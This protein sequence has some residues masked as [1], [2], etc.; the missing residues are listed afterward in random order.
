MTTPE[1]TSASAAWPLDAHLKRGLFNL[2]PVSSSSPM[3]KTCLAVF[4][5]L[6][7]AHAE[8]PSAPATWKSQQPMNA[9]AAKGDNWWQTFN[10]A[11]LTKLIDE[12]K[13]TYP[14]LKTALARVDQARAAVRTARA[15]WFPTVMAQGDL[16]RSRASDTVYQFSFGTLSNYGTSIELAYELDLWGRIR[17]QVN[18]AKSDE[19]GANADAYTYGLTLSGEIARVYFTLRSLD[20]ESAVLSDTLKLRHEALDMATA[21]VNAGATNELDRV[22]AEAE[23]ATTEAE[24]AALVGPR[25]ELE[26]TLGLMLGRVASSY[27]MAAGR[28]PEALPDV[29][30]VLPSELV[31]RRPDV[32]ATMRRVEAAQA[33]IGVARAA[34]FPK[35]T[36]GAGLGTQTSQNDKYLDKDSGTWGVGLKFSVPLFVG[37]QRKAAVD[38]ATAAAKEASTQYEEKVLTAFKEVESLMARLEAQQRQSKAQENLQTAADAAAKLARQRY[39]EGITTYLEVIEAERTSLSARRALVQL[40]GQRLVTTVQLIQALGGGWSAAK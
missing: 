33:R 17:G 30:K 10:D 8:T 22:R 16:S 31:Q 34:Y 25:A 3:K 11:Q 20:D 5:T 36:L 15:G 6:A 9:A 1:R 12:A 40:R 37:G 14:G 18:A 29:P 26:N 28:L 35:V 19:A 7:F 39:T 38:A 23:L 4:G 24:I 27:K 21:R 32:S 13:A 2:S